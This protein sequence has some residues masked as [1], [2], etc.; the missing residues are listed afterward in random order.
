MTCERC[1]ADHAAHTIRDGGLHESLCRD[2][3]DKVMD[4]KL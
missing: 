4:A 2:C 3:W 1:G